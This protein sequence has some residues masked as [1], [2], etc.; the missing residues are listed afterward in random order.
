MNVYIDMKRLIIALL[1]VA[2]AL[3]GCGVKQPAGP[4]GTLTEQD[5]KKAIT[6]LFN[7][8]NS[9]N[10]D[11][12]KKYVGA[13]GPVADQLIEKLKGNVKVRDI[14]DIKIQGTTVQATV[15]V[16]VVP[17]KVEKDLPL[18]FD[19]TKTLMLTSPL[20]LLTLLL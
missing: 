11:T 10:V 3:S 18:T 7:G 14:R 19:I 6:D 2:L 4:T 1:L 20:R 8:I 15:T 13:T 17:L 12:V 5:V 16:E 9:G